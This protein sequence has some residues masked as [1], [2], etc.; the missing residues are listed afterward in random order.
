MIIGLCV[1][2]EVFIMISTPW[3]IC[4]LQQRTNFRVLL[5]L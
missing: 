5:F 2:D 1:D 3:R 4:P